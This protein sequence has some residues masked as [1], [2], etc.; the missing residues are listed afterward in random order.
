VE[1]WA[2]TTLDSVARE[3]ETHADAY[4]AQL[5]RLTSTA[6]PDDTA[7]TESTLQDM[8]FLREKLDLEQIGEPLESTVER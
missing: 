6:A 7:G 8:A 2:R 5:Q 3:F 1:V 4:R